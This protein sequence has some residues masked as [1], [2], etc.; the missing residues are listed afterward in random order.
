MINQTS[1]TKKLIG[2][3]TTA[4]FLSATPSFAQVYWGAGSTNAH[5]DSIGRFASTDS[6][7]TSL[8][9]STTATPAAAVWS[10]SRT[11]MSQGATTRSW[12]NSGYTGVITS[13]SA[14]DGSAIMDSDFRATSGAA[15]P[16]NAVLES[17][18]IDLSAA[19]GTEV[20]VKFYANYFEFQ[21]TDLQ[22]GISVDGGATWSDVEYRNFTGKNGVRSAYNGWVFVPMRNALDGLTA[23]QLANCKLR[24]KFNGNYYFAAIDDVSIVPAPAYD[25]ALGVPQVGNT[26]GSSFHTVRL[27]NNMY[28][29]LSQVDTMEFQYGAKMVNL[30]NADITAADQA[31]LKIMVERESAGSWV[32]EGSDSTFIDALVAESDTILI[33]GSIDGWKPTQ[34]GTYRTTYSVGFAGATDGYT[35]NNTYVD[36]F[37]ITDNYYSKVPRRADGLPAYTGRSFPAASGT[38][39]VSEFEYGSMFFFPKGATDRMM[40]DSVTFIGYMT[41][42][43]TPSFAGRVI[44]IRV[45]KYSESTSDADATLDA[46]NPNPELTLLALGQDTLT[47]VTAGYKLGSS[48]ATIQDI[49][50]GAA[51]HFMDTTIYLISLEQTDPNGL[52]TSANKFRGYWYGTYDIN[53]GINASLYSDM[54]IPSP[55]RVGEITTSGAAGTNDWNWVGYG[56]DMA[57]SIGVHISKQALS[58]VETVESGA[59]MKMFPNP[60]ADVLNVQVDLVETSNVQY[61]MTDASGRVVRMATHKNVQSEVVS[62]DV[63][64]LAAGVYFMSIKTS[65]GVS[66]QRF[67]KH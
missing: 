4:L 52:E 49:S 46:A 21:I 3:A 53:Y 38:N 14:A 35:G 62:F 10:F 19:V 2:A 37:K 67:V 27:S 16:H 50:T 12:A 23:A 31:Y 55:V 66:T 22:V 51:Y 45:A 20:A 39:L 24:F 28:Q 36:S 34:V 33:G 60:T 48:G 26:L 15:A 25:I 54:A 17:P 32:L 18:T 47:S 64:N 5:I 58:S 61:I 29:P 6:S 1:F 13:P 43:D 41:A 57:P 42:A 11:G 65:K 63:Q 7:L 44:S 59:A 56:A 40:L 9:Y 30:G 8:G